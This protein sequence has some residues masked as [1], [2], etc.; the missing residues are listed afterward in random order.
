MDDYN[1]HRHNKDE[2]ITNINYH[3]TLPIINLDIFDNNHIK[4]KKKKHGELL[5]HSVRAGFFGESG[6]G[7]TMAVLTLIF[8]PNGLRFENIYI[9]CKSLYQ[10]KYKLLETV[11]KNVKEVGYFPFD[12]NEN[13]IDLKN[14]RKN[15]IMIFDDIATE[16]QNKVCTYFSMGRHKAVDVIFIIQSYMKLQKH[17]C[18]EN[19]NFLV[20]FRQDVLNMKH[21]FEEHVVPDMTFDK[22][23]N[24]CSL[25]WEDRYG[26]L[27]IAKDFELN[28]GR[29]RYGF[30][31]YIKP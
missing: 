21:I 8:H 31:K 3:P 23:K 22:F 7:K 17:L 24:I 13:V 26:F 11:L 20:I 10:S 1:K 16:K 30:D 15:S 29:Y 6:C 4:T 5:P 12:E 18:R 14:A 2:K 9:F 25:C 19:L 27:V 28:D